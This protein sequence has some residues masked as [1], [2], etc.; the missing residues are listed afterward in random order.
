MIPTNP[1]EDIISDLLWEED[2]LILHELTPEELHFMDRQ[3]LFIGG[4]VL[5]Y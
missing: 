1:M 4:N 3:T 5:G 2:R